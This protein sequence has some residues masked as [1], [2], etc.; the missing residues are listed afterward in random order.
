[1]NKLNKKL[2]IVAV[3][4]SVVGFISGY[5]YKGYEI[6]KNFL[7]F[8]NNFETSNKDV[9]DSQSQKTNVTNKEEIEEYIDNININVEIKEYDSYIDSQNRFNDKARSLYGS[10]KNK[11]DKNIKSAE[12]LV[13]FLDDAGNPIYENDYNPLYNSDKLESVILKPNYSNEFSFNTDGVPSEWS[14]Q[15]EYRISDLSFK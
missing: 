15:I 1:M 2:I 11:G 6:R 13:K 8:A 9:V 10:I 12:L 7:G 4:F 3:I 5:F 14:G